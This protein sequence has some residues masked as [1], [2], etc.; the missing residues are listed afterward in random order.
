MDKICNPEWMEKIA[1]EMD[2]IANEYINAKT[3]LDYPKFNSYHEAISVIREEF[4]ELWDEIKIQKKDMP[5]V[6]SLSQHQKIRKEAIQLGAMV[7]GFIV[8]LTE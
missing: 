6:L 4:E 1:E 3:V 2:N 5:Q 8:K 7:L